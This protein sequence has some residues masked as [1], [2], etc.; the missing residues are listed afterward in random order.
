[1]LCR[2]CLEF[3]AKLRT[4]ESFGGAK[5]DALRLASWRS[6]KVS[7]AFSAVFWIDRQ[8][9][10]AQRTLHIWLMISELDFRGESRH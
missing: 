5:Q 7:C 9:R 6:K 4:A 1:V 8:G 10:A 3:F 2:L